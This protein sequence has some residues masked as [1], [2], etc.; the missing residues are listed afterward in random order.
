[1]AT[2]A[3]IRQ[4]VGEDLALVPIGQDLDSEHQVRIDRAFDQVYQILK[5]RGLASWSSTADVPEMLVPYVALII[6]EKLLTAYSVPESR[7]QRIKRDAGEDG[8]LAMNK[9][10][11]L[12]TPEYE[13]VEDEM[14]F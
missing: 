12:T 5:T 7:Y 10:A 4:M 8:M 11:F 14:N 13:S 3:E 6:E 9:I 2:K 1:M